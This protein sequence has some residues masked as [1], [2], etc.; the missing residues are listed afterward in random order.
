VW[1]AGGGKCLG[2]LE[3]HSEWV[4]CVCVVEVDA[5]GDGGDVGGQVQRVVSG[6]WDNTLRV[7]DAGGGKCLGVLEGH[8]DW[9]NCVCVVEVDAGGDGGDVGGKVQRVVS[10]SD[11]NTLRVWD[12]AADGSWVA[13]L[14]LVLPGCVAE[15]S[16]VVDRP[17]SL[18][19]VVR[20]GAIF[21]VDTLLEEVCP[22][23]FPLAV[24]TAR[25]YAPGQV[26]LGA[27]QRVHFA[28]LLLE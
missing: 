4:T 3:G 26:V 24:R 25:A 9:V 22:L 19:C 18:L 17:G 20:T 5:G 27:E 16:V 13:G 2:V 8:S 7:W 14:V 21:L 10:G 23:A 1:D 28:R 15:L 6:S 11:D 12:A